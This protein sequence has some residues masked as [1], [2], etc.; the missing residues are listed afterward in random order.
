MSVVL[1]LVPPFARSLTDGNRRLAQQLSKY[2]LTNDEWMSAG[3]IAK[4]KEL[5]PEFRKNGDRV[6][7]FSQFTQVLDILEVVLDTMDIKYL[8][9]TGQTNV[10]ERQGLCDAYNN[11]PDITVFRQFSSHY[12]SR[13]GARTLIL[14][15][16]CCSSVNSC[17]WTWL[18]LDCGEHCHVLRLRLQVSRSS[19]CHKCSRLMSSVRQI[20]PT[21]T[22][23]QKIEPTGLDKPGEWLVR[24]P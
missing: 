5:L 18:E 20:A 17:W 3:K 12:G 24:R 9:L 23:K 10:T 22:S 11:D 2:C 8:K 14:L 13:L 6:L 16:C 21:T 7:I 19:V 1:E 4:L 15:P